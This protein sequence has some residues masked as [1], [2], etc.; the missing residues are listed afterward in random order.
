MYLTN[1][2]FVWAVGIEQQLP[3]N[4]VVGVEYHATELNAIGV[5]KNWNALPNSYY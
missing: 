4:M 3:L 5:S 1:K 2:D